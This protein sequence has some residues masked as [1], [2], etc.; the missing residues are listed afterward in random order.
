[1]LFRAALVAV[2]VLLLL[3][4]AEGSATVLEKL[5]PRDAELAFDYAPYRMLRMSHAPWPLNRDGFRA[6]ELETYR[7]HFVVEFLGGSVCLGVGTNTGPTV[8]DH[9]QYA[10]DRLGLSRAQVLNLCQGG[11][12]SAQELAIFVQYGLPIK[13]QVVLSL[14]G[15]NDLLHPR[16]VGSDDAPNLPYRDREMRASFD[17]HHSVLSHLALVRLAGRLA[18]RHPE[19]P[20]AHPPVPVNS[21]LDSYTYMLE[22]TRQ[23][24][25]SS[26]A[27]YAVLFQ[28]TLHYRKKW[29]AG[30]SSMWQQR[31]PQYGAATSA[32]VRET[33]SAADRYLSNWA[34]ATGANWIDLTNTFAGTP[35]TVYSD[36]V[37]FAS[38]GGNLALFDELERR[39]LVAD[40][41]ARYRV[42]ER[43]E[44]EHSAGSPL[45]E[46]RARDASGHFSWEQ[47]QLP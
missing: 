1:M 29:S 10:L 21:V 6:R 7:D 30:E 23:L 26:G 14:N 20:A 2:Q 34:K 3:G 15:A 38:E 27:T 5:R 9:L 18:A 19:N 12:T 32:A 39:G 40:I 42:W 35:G 31:D 28:P 22:V 41:E 45:V 4:L 11:A 47:R 17:G 44:R 8:A 16:P 46:S 25:E 24:A 33:Y 36:S 43:R 13:P 37:H